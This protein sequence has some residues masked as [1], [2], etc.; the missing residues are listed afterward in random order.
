MRGREPLVR[1]HR[2]DVQSSGIRM[3]NAEEGRAEGFHAV[4]LVTCKLFGF[5][6]PK[7][8]TRNPKP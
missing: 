2:P 4:L 8:E 1:L 5:S 3:P 6:S 7:P